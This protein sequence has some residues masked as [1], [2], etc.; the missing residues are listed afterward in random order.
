MHFILCSASETCELGLK[1]SS[2]CFIYGSYLLD[3]LRVQSK[4]II[5]RQVS[6]FDSRCDYI[7][8]PRGL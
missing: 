4:E 1:T 6:Y 5:L 3:Y 8:V 7:D 2:L